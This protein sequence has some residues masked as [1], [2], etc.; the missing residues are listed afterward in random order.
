MLATIGLE[1][2]VSA[3]K[4]VVSNINALLIILLILLGALGLSVLAARHVGRH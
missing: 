1:M 2:S 3:A 4:M